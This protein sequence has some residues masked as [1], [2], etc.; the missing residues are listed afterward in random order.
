LG[1]REPARHDGGMSL[2]S[3]LNALAITFNG[4]GHRQLTQC[5]GRIHPLLEPAPLHARTMD[6]STSRLRDHVDTK[7]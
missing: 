7:E 1:Q 4:R 2:K 6:E 5:Q 3:P